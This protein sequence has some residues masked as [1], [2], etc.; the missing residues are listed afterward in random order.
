VLVT[1]SGL[2]IYIYIYIYIYQDTPI[3]L[4]D[5]EAERTGRSLASQYIY[6]CIVILSVSLWRIKQ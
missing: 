3:E 2:Y 1:G 4:F 5:A 6:I